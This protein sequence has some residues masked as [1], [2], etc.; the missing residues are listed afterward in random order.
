MVL[1]HPDAFRTIG[2][3]SEAKPEVFS[4]PFF[5]LY[6]GRYSPIGEQLLAK[7]YSEFYSQE[8]L[9]ARCERVRAFFGGGPSRGEVDYVRDELKVKAILVTLQDGLW[10]E[11]GALAERYGTAAE[12]DA[13][14]VYVATPS[15]TNE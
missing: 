6:A 14:R 15:L 4:N 7:I 3:P 2:T 9:D 10:A 8:D 11:P 1:C 12:T 5:A 13:Y